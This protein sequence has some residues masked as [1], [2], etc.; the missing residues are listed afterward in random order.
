[1]IPFKL[2]YADLFWSISSVRLRIGTRDHS[3]RYFARI[4]STHGNVCIA[5]FY[6]HMYICTKC[7]STCC[8]WTLWPEECWKA[9]RL[10]RQW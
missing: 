10:T 6:V 9:D 1:M 4:R 8:T 7:V 3:R 5:L 2:S